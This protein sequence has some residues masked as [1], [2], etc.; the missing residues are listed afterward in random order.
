MIC[1]SGL[2]AAFFGRPGLFRSAFLWASCLFIIA[3]P[4]GAS[5][6]RSHQGLVF[7]FIDA[8]QADSILITRGD[9]SMLIDA[10]SSFPGSDA[11]R[12]VVGPH[13]LKRGITKIDLVVMTHAHPDHIGGMP[14]ILSRFE[15]GEVW[16]N[17]EHGPSPDFLSALYIARQKAIPVTC[18]SL[19]DSRTLG[20]IQVQ[21]LNPPEGAVSGDLNL[22]SVVLRAGDA[23]MRGLFMAD[24]CGLGEIRLSR[25]RQDISAHVLKVAHHGSKQSCLDMFLDRVR[26]S[27]AVIPVGLRNRYRLPHDKALARLKARG[28]AV[29]RTDESGGITVFSESGQLHV[30]SGLS[31]SDKVFYSTTAGVQ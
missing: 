22:D 9:K 5:L 29:F 26:P 3:L 12:F 19:G 27:L 30:K 11:G 23:G 17:A 20:G 24:A 31:S 21:V 15:V 18:V 2:V 7:D 28:I 25:L 14:F 16:T 8:G 13:L 10:G 1:Y 4:F 6:V